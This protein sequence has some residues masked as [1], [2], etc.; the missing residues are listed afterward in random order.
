MTSSSRQ[1][2]KL[3]KLQVHDVDVPSGPLNFNVIVFLIVLRV[4]IYSYLF[5][6]F[7]PF[8]AML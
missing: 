4:L 5:H 3:I 1:V 7:R 6:L 2:D 8:V